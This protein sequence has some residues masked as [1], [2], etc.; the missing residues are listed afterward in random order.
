MRTIEGRIHSRLDEG[1]IGQSGSNGKRFLVVGAILSIFGFGVF[2]VLQTLLGHVVGYMWV[3]LTNYLIQ[4]IVSFLAYGK[5]VFIDSAP[6]FLSYFRYVTGTTLNFA[7]SGLMLVVFVEV[8]LFSPIISRAISIIVMAPLMYFL[9][10][11]YSFRTKSE[12]RT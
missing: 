7:L 2:V 6:N 1:S 8:L 12:T 9:H 4:T 11:K 3:Y 10:R 5:F